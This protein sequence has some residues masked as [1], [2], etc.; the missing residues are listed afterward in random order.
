MAAEVLRIPVGERD[1]TGGAGGAFRVPEQADAVARAEEAL[2]GVRQKSPPRRA[3]KDH[4]G[5]SQSRRERLQLLLDFA[6]YLA[7]LAVRPIG[8]IDPRL[9]G[10]RP[11]GAR[12]SR[13]DHREGAV[14]S[15]ESLLLA[16]GSEERVA[17]VAEDDRIL[18][19]EAVGALQLRKPFRG[20]SQLQQ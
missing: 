13:A 5:P 17:E 18:R 2:V 10:C 19:R 11:C 4:G 9:G 20:P 16:A 14:E 15:G 3:G 12:P 7:V 8:R 1:V 6:P